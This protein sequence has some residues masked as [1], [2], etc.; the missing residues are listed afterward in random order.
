MAARTKNRDD[1]SKESA[2]RAL[3]LI[4]TAK[5]D[6][7]RR[8]F[9]VGK[10]G[11]TA[12]VVVIVRSR[13][14]NVAKSKLTTL[15]YDKDAKPKPKGIKI[16]T[17]PEKATY[18]NHGY[19]WWNQE[20]Q[21]LIIA[22]VKKPTPVLSRDMR[23]YFRNQWGIQPFWRSAQFENV[24][25][26]AD[27]EPDGVESE[28]QSELEAALAAINDASDAD[29]SG[30]EDQ[31]LVDNWKA[32]LADEP[33][34][35]AEVDPAPASA[36]PAFV[37]E[38]AEADNDAPPPYSAEDKGNGLD[39]AIM[40][41]AQRLVKTL[42]AIPGFGKLLTQAYAEDPQGT[43]ALLE[44]LLQQTT[45]ERL[46]L[47][48]VGSKDMD[49]LRDSVQNAPAEPLKADDSGI[50]E[51]A[52]AFLAMGTH[53]AEQRGA[54]RPEERPVGTQIRNMVRQEWTKYPNMSPEALIEKLK[55]V[56]VPIFEKSP[57]ARLRGFLGLSGKLGAQAPNA[58]ADSLAA[59]VGVH[60]QNWQAANKIV[61]SQIDQLKG[62]VS[63][64]LR[65]LNMTV[66]GQGGSWNK[67]DAIPQ[68]L[69]ALEIEKKLEAL[70]AAT[71]EEVRAQRR[72]A[73]QAAIDK[74][75][76]Y[77]NGLAN[78]LI[79]DLDDN[80][81]E[82]PGEIRKTVVGTLTEILQAVAAH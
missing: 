1:F 17:L 79:T 80:P 48:A 73:C 19:L 29:L 76:N 78:E 27:A 31:S 32:E 2:K 53:L 67:V 47:K 39:P 81:F 24:H 43:E 9:A 68:S 8:A 30:E 4:R 13:Q 15:H 7:Q 57:D 66:E 34:A 74:G 37:E 35:Y 71:T 82:V 62:K 14:P 49:A 38:A 40:A 12:P 10:F 41:D 77:V 64:V 63:E 55:S 25:A 52:D 70:R 36:K 22:C 5:S 75:L 26:G 20:E 72:A 16:E 58:L 69:Q 56:F 3:A 18:T 59:A 21:R 51:V 61:I 6:K 28:D 45:Y 42:S 44:K 11:T 54:I 50:D 23:R 60:L 46:L 65:P 33:P